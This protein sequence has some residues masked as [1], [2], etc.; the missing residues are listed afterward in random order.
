[1][2][3]RMAYALRKTS[4]VAALLAATLLAP[5][6]AEAH[7]RPLYAGFG[8]GPHIDLDCCR[9]HGRL[10]GELGIHFSRDDRGFFLAFE[11]INTFGD[12]F[13]MFLGGIRLGGD[14]EVYG[15]H[16]YGILLRPSALIGF[17][18]RDYHGPHSG[19]G[20]WGV[21][22]VQPAFDVRFV[23]AHRVLALWLRPVSFD[24][25][26]Y[27]DRYRPNRDLYWGVG[28]QFMLGLDF[29]FG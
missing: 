24:F 14:I 10:Q 25:N 5:S 11:V 2:L 20:D 19:W 23:F 27:L 8:G 9:V 28:Y 3:G 7:D 15:R 1:M 12:D 17:G 13:Y 22:V 21:F 18:W 26:I 6:L 29:Q 16:D 4:L